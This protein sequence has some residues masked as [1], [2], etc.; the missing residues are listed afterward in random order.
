MKTA[1]TLKYEVIENVLPKTVFSELTYMYN[2]ML[3]KGLSEDKRTKNSMFTK[4]DKY[5]GYSYPLHP[6][7][8]YPGDAR[9]ILHSKQYI[10]SISKLLDVEL[11][12]EVM[13]TFHYLKPNFKSGWLHTDN[14][15]VNFINNP[16][17]SGPRAGV[18]YQSTNAHEAPNIL[19]RRRAVACILYINDQWSLGDGGQTCLY[20]KND[21]NSLVEAV[22]PRPNSVSMFRIDEGSWH[23]SVSQLTP[24]KVMVWWYH[25]P[26]ETGRNLGKCFLQ[27]GVFENGG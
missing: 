7:F 23:R 10:D 20:E 5:D 3:R 15:Q 9:N 2:S 18:V 16:I 26:V 12:Y 25:A 11:T 13:S 17:K 4:F 1:S 24:R 14:E 8:T 19:K 6:A 21:V 27:G 22:E